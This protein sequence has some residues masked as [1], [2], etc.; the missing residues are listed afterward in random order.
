MKLTWLGVAACVIL[1]RD[2]LVCC[3]AAS[4]FLLLLKQLATLVSTLVMSVILYF[5]H[6]IC[7]VWFTTAV[8]ITITIFAILDVVHTLV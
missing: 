8:V 2:C 5:Y 6:K 7:Q 1:V 3:H 4:T